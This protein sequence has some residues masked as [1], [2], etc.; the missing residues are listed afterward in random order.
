MMEPGSENP[1]V[2]VPPPPH[3]QRQR[4]GKHPLVQCLVCHRQLPLRDVLPAD[5]VR[6]PVHRLLQE[7]V[8]D[9]HDDGYICHDDLNRYRSRYLERLLSD[10][11]GEIDEIRRAIVHSVHEAEVVSVNPD[12]EFEERATLGQRLSDRLA[13]FGGS[14]TFLMLFS[15]FMFVWILINSLALISPPDPFPFI[16][17][18]LVL[19]CLAAVQAPIIMMSQNRQEA[20]DRARAAHDYSVNLKAEVEVRAMSERMDRLI[21]HQWQRLMEIQQVQIELLDEIRLVNQRRHS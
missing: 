16:L 10:E 1:A 8:K 12:E 17:L 20:K 6:R 7:D 9:W 13:R 18:N 11:E 19:S 5:L 2:G 4:G 15:A 14:W 21:T 3:H